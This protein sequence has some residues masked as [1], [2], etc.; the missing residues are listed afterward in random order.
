MC[1]PG[2]VGSHGH[3]EWEL[4]DEKVNSIFEA[5]DE[6]TLLPSQ[7]KPSDILKGERNFR[8]I[9]TGVIATTASSDNTVTQR[10][11]MNLDLNRFLRLS[12]RL[13]ILYRCAL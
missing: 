10:G 2:L 1:P 12:D 11:Q 8:K 13:K 9:V 7:R 3:Q 5:L 6:K 4:P